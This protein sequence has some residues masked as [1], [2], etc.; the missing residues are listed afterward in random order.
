MATTS[1]QNS[2]ISA[3]NN[4]TTTPIQVAGANP[5]RS[6][7]TFHNVGLAAGAVDVIVFPTT[8]LQGIAGGGS[9][10]LAPTTAAL[11]GGFRIFATGG[12]R[13]VEGAAARQAWQALSVS[14]S[15]NPLTVM[16]EYN[17]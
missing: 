15:G 3:F 14:G 1:L 6:K 13:V 10:A 9:V 2:T 16:E 5:S 17:K 7:I 12:D 8:V 11:G 4:L